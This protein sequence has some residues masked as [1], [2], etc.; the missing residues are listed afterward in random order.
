M[1]GGRVFTPHY[2][3]PEQVRGETL[4]TATDVYALGVLL[5]V[6]LSG[7]HPT[8]EKSRSPA[9][10]VLALLEKEPA[11]L[12]LGDLDHIL[13]KALAKHPAER[14]QTVALFGHD[15]ERYLR[16]EP[17]TAR[18]QTL[19]Y[20]LRR[21]AS[22]NRAAV[23]AGMLAAAGLVAA[24]IFSVGQ[25]REARRQRDL[26]IQQTHIAGA[27][28][29]FQSAL[30][31]QVGERPITMREALDSGR[32]V[33]E[34][35]FADNPNALMPILVQLAE[36]YGEMGNVDIGMTLVSRA[37]SL[38]IATRSTDQLTFVLC[39]K[40]NLHRLDG[41]YHLAWQVIQSAD[42]LPHSNDPHLRVA[43]LGRRATIGSEVDSAE[44]SVVWAQT[45]MA[46]KDSLGETRDLEYVSL[47]TTY[48]LGLDES[49][50]SR[51]SVGALVRTIAL[52]DSTGHGSTITRDVAS[53]N[54]ATALF[55]LGETRTAETMLHDVLLSAASADTSMIPWQPLIHYAETALYQGHPDSAAKY[56]AL[57]V[58]QAVRGNNLFW[59]GRGLF[60]L[61]RAQ[62][63]LGRTDEAMRA[64]RR[65][66][67][68]IQSYPHVR[69]TDDVF[70]DGPT[71]EGNVALFR[72]D[73]TD[74][75]LLFRST[76]TGN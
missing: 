18:G 74:A 59:E 55:R 72:G 62:A 28:L 5:Y 48:A 20:R 15:L 75:Q 36:N 31:S 65:L 64:K 16:K 19:I 70:P 61:A 54:A 44:A 6:L 1:E 50:R 32:V 24:T 41:D 57:I 13:A 73:T 51:E 40:A 35:R 21:F 68:I 23:I 56:F 11:P 46:I 38:A 30:L 67:A 33:L 52:I 9:E 42:S 2:A 3:A 39:A 17:V 34:R 29:D 26:A 8:A 37:E 43:C 76:L 47:L 60:G 12:K 14:Y 25:M 49:G 10:T 7:Q 4:T 45:A 27:Q 58:R 63:Q 22:R 69:D 53:H 71:I 66:D